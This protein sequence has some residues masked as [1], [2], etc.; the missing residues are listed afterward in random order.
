MGILQRAFPSSTLRLDNVART[1]D[2]ASIHHLLNCTELRD[3][4]IC[5]TP[6]P[7]R[8]ARHWQEVAALG[9]LHGSRLQLQVSAHSFQ[10]L[11]AEP[12]LAAHVS[13][14]T[15][16]WG[17]D[18]GRSLADQVSS[19]SSL[20]KLMLHSQDLVLGKAGMLDALRQ[21]SLLQS[22]HCSAN[23]M[24]MLLVESVPSTW[25]LL[26]NLQL[27]DFQSVSLNW[28]LV[29]QQCPQL[30][31]LAIS[32]AVPL[33]LTALTSLTRHYWEPRDSDSFQCSQLGHL[34]VPW[35]V[36]LNLLPSTL[37]SLSLH[38]S[39]HSMTHI[40]DL[41]LRCQQSLV[42]I[43]F[44]SILWDLSYIQGLMPAVQSP[45]L[46]TSVTSV[47]LIIHPQAFTLPHMDGSMAGQHIHHLVTWFPML[48]R[49]HIGH[50]MHWRNLTRTAET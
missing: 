27:R 10:M 31:G 17:A 35:R 30:Q 42:H 3:L 28:S 14:A 4:T 34:H 5:P 8:R 9:R 40:P 12:S 48:Q 24:Q 36:N 39:G 44:T 26:T 16:A 43:S 37:T 23:V 33:C 2:A 21:L 49:L 18:A 6:K 19:L 1:A 13:Q 22:L 50:W 29:E 46:S 38:H 45:A 15:L 47:E 41:D 20:T 32:K 7:V 25:S 11:E